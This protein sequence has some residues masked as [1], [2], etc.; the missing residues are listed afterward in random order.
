MLSSSLKRSESYQSLFW[1]CLLL[2][3]QSKVQ[4]LHDILFSL[5]SMQNDNTAIK[6]IIGQQEE[7]HRVYHS[8]TCKYMWAVT[9]KLLSKCSIIHDYIQARKKSG[10]LSPRR[11]WQ[12][13][14]GM[15]AQI[16]QYQRKPLAHRAVEP[17]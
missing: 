7:L 10:H 14:G 6:L 4:E 3:Y 1:S 5:G 9:K 11:N 17:Y 15:L 2:L 8:L 12:I 16:E 13:T